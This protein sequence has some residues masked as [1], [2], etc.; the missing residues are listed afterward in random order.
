M[1]NLCF[2]VMHLSQRATL[3]MCSAKSRQVGHRGGESPFCH[4]RRGKP[5]FL[6][7][8]LC[9]TAHMLLVAPLNTSHLSP[10]L[11]LQRKKV[12]SPAGDAPVLGVGW[13]SC[14]GRG[15]FVVLQHRWQRWGG[16]SEGRVGWR[17]CRLKLSSAGPGSAALSLQ[18][19]L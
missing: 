15:G 9:T 12:H 1:E 3:W 7:H 2:F 5:A 11:H 8:R 4:L 10:R 6:P 17:R 19:H 13:L 14:L 16:S 18:S